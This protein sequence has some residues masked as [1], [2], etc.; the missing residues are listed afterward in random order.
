M[1]RSTIVAIKNFSL[2]FMFAAF[3][4]NLA[5]VPAFA[6]DLPIRKF[7]RLKV[8]PHQVTI[9]GLSSGAFMAVQLD[10]AYSSMFKGAAIFAGGIYGCAEGS[11]SQALDTCMAHPESLVVPHF[12]SLARAA[13]KAG[14]IDSLTQL[15]SQKVY[16]FSGTNDQTVLPAAAEKLR[17]FYETFVSPEGI[18]SKTDLPS[19]HGMPTQNYG[20]QCQDTTSPW[21]LNCSYDGAGAALE[22]LMGPLQAPVEAIS[23]HLYSF[24]QTSLVTPNS[25]MQTKGYVYV[26]DACFGSKQPCPLHVALHGCRQGAEFIGNTFYTH[27]GYNEWAEANQF[28]VLYPDLESTFLS[29]PKGCWDWWGYT[30]ANYSTRSGAHMLSIVN[31]IKAAEGQ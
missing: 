18:V 19:G 13:E 16:L 26:P 14:A 15:N 8:D 30:G 24:D 28:V 29:N 23:S 25:S 2:Q 21:I 22:H 6:K 31:I 1:I 5:H 9:S 27:A 11:V 4:T 12:L 17:K 7:R 20:A 10:V 3:L